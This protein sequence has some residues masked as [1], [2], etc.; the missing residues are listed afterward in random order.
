MSGSG[1]EENA[2]RTGGRAEHLII[3]TAFLGDLL[4]G[5]PLFKE[6]RRLYPDDKLTVLCRKGLGKFLLESG[7]VDEAIEAEKT[8]KE[9]WKAAVKELRSRRF[10]LLLCPH[11]SPRSHLLVLRLRAKR[12]I[13]YRSRFNLLVFNDR[14]ERPM[15]LPE[16][17]RQLALLQPLDSQWKLRLEGYG[18]LQF[19]AGG[20]SESGLTP[21]P[22]WASMDVPRLVELR[23]RF[24]ANGDVAGTSSSKI[25]EIIERAGLHRSSKI[26]FLAPGS[27]WKTK[28]WTSDGFT[29]AARELQGLGYRV[30]LMGTPSEK[31]ICDD[32]AF[33][34]PGVVSLAGETSLFESAE[35]LAFAD[36]LICN[37]SGAMHM[38]AAAGVP[39]VS[40]FGPTVLRFGY[41]PWQN[42]ARVVQTELPCRPCGKHGAEKCPLGTHAC[43]KRVPANQVLEVAQELRSEIESRRDP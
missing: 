37:D 36:L 38:A 20:Q 10:D 2:H 17:L 39:T 35:M 32:I 23:E 24:R 25:G 11:E 3:Q 8:N 43:M 30:F 29:R 34:A 12:K 19:E 15:H 18:R 9:S 4:L 33:R 42:D 41:R 16:A 28:M 40:V 1:R 14:I 27:V 7:L 31:T 6:M 26:A 5:I 21:V 13:G 22:E